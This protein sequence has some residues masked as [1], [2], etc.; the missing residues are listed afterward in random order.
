MATISTYDAGYRHT[1]LAITS[2]PFDA[3]LLF[4]PAF[5][6]A[7]KLACKQKICIARRHRT[8]IPRDLVFLGIE[9]RVVDVPGQKAQTPLFVDLG[10]DMVF[11]AAVSAEPRGVEAVARGFGILELPFK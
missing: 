6:V 2:Q 9:R 3:V 11:L 7:L 1:L 8:E 5:G 4:S 10:H